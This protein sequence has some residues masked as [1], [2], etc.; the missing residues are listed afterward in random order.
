MGP[1]RLITVPEPWSENEAR[2]F[3]SRHGVLYILIAVALVV[4]LY[5][6]P[7]HDNAQ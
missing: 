3:I 4:V 7:H 2:L 1:L 5:S 6:V